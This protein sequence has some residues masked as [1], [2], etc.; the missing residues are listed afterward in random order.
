VGPADKPDRGVVGFHVSGD[1]G[2]ATEGVSKLALAKPRE[3][4]P[5]RGANGQQRESGS[6]WFCMVRPISL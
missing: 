3:E 2:W 1:E 5:E 4:Q 6:C